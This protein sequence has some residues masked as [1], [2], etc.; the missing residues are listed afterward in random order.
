MSPNCKYI[1][2]GRSIRY[3]YGWLVI[4]Y[5]AKSPRGNYKVITCPAQCDLLIKTKGSA[6]ALV[7]HA[8][9]SYLAKCGRK[10]RLQNAD[11]TTC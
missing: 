2:Y 8:A 6:V 3:H 9:A 10:M 7:R 5:V 1:T 4:Q 11:K